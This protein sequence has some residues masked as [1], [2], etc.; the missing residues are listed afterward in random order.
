MRTTFR[1]HYERVCGEQAG[2]TAGWFPAAVQNQ[3]DN[4]FDQG[5]TQSAIHTCFAPFLQLLL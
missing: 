4:T 1:H 2:R 5:E 3:E